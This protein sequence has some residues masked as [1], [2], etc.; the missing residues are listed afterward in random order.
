[1]SIKRGYIDRSYSISFRPTVTAEQG[2]SP[3][4]LEVPLNGVA[5]SFGDL[6]NPSLCFIKN[7]GRTTG[8]AA[9]TDYIELGIRDPGLN[10]F[11][12]LLSLKAGEGYAIR[13]SPNLLEE[14]TGTGTGT[15]APGNQLWLKA[16]G[17]AQKVQL[18]AY[19]E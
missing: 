19:D 14:Y 10:V 5:V 18:E 4:F 13:L 3:G 8:T 6:D 9:T 17:A 12:P 2:P 16:I 7:I 11:Y 15:T 1:M